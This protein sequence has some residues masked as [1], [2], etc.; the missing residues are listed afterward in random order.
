MSS[1]K[2]RLDRVEKAVSG[3]RLAAVRTACE[4]MFAFN[5]SLHANTCEPDGVYVCLDAA[6]RVSAIVAVYGES[7]R[8]E[9]L[10]YKE[11]QASSMM[12]ADGFTR[13]VRLLIEQARR[14]LG[15]AHKKACKPAACECST[16]EQQIKTAILNFPDPQKS[17]MAA[18]MAEW[19]EGKSWR[20]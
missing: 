10:A 9:A 12:P 14:V 5:R 19:M 4:A 20:I 1:I 11:G 18:I 6:Q 15:N 8:P 17:E 13:R 16:N 7:A 2:A 3:P